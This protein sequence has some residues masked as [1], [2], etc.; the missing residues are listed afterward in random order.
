MEEECLT[1]KFW[2]AYEVDAEESFKRGKCR[3]YPPVIDSIAVNEEIAFY[4]ENGKEMPDTDASDAAVWTQPATW[5]SEWC[6]EYRSR[7]SS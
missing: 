6:G 3:R 5:Q 2:Q 7:T 1:C 4:K